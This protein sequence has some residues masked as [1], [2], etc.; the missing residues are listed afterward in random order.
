MQVAAHLAYWQLVI[1]YLMVAGFQVCLVPPDTRDMS[2]DVIL[3]LAGFELYSVCLAL[4]SV[5]IKPRLTMHC[6]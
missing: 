4:C 3:G 1:T 2:H 5:A 6:K